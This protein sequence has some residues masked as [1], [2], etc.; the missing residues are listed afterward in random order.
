[1]V[2]MAAMADVMKRSNAPEELP[3]SSRNSSPEE[4]DGRAGC[5]FIFL[6]K[7]TELGLLCHPRIISTNS[8]P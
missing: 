2:S 8:Y 7:D 3:T 1:M 4:E 6:I 5:W